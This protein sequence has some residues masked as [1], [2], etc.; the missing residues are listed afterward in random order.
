[1]MQRAS[2]ALEDL[3]ALKVAVRVLTAI[4]EHYKPNS[5][6]VEKLRRFAPLLADRPID[7]LA[8]EVVH[9]ELKR[10]EEKRQGKVAMN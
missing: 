7:E 1:M 9:A 8:C 10:R 4:L 5:S 2:V 6:D 3:A